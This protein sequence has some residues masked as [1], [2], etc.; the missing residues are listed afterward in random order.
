MGE[1]VSG[2]R[3]AQQSCDLTGFRRETDDLFRLYDL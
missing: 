3:S 1:A 2:S